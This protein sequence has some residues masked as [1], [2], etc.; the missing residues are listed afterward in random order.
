MEQVP[1]G[2]EQK[3]AEYLY[4]QLNQLEIRLNDLTAVVHKDLILQQFTFSTTTTDTDP[5]TGKLQIDNAAKASAT[6]LYISRYSLANIDLYEALLSLRK[7]DIV[8]L[9]LS[10][11]ITDY[12]KYYVS[13]TAVDGTTYI[14]VPLSKITTA[15]AEFANG[16]T[17]NIGVQ[18]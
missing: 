12:A 7:R 5:G 1:F 6:Y 3:L 9:S 17:L 2:T 10:T 11:N 16:A 13:S 18:Y 15:G 14:K 4:R 8:T